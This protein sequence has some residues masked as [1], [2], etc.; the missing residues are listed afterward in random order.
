MHEGRGGGEAVCVEEAD[1][2][3]VALI[4]TTDKHVVTSHITTITCVVICALTGPQAHR[5]EE[6]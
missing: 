5:T 4:S 3:A 6:S 1:A 2:P